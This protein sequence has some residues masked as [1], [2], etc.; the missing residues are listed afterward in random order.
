[1]PEVVT[2]RT[3]TAAVASLL[4][5]LCSF[6]MF[7]PAGL[8]PL[9]A[10]TGLPALALGLYALRAVNA[11]D[12]RLRGRRLALPGI[13]LGAAGTAVTVVGVVGMVPLPPRAQAGLAGC[14]N[15]PRQVGMAVNRYSDSHNQQL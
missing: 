12:G 5:G 8:L 2:A 4:L 11:S 7:G 3:S 13:L 1:M 6:A 10:L 9:F 15:T 14:A